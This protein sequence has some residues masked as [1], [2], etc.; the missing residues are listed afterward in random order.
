MDKDKEIGALREKI[1]KMEEADSN[2][3]ICRG[4]D[5][6]KRH[7]D[8][9]QTVKYDDFGSTE[10]NKE[11]IKAKNKDERVNVKECDVKEDKKQFLGNK[12]CRDAVADGNKNHI[13]NMDVAEKAVMK[14]ENK[15]EASINN[16]KED[17]NDVKENEDKERKL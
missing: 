2:S 17:D 4:M 6:E 11:H 14:D 16:N 10:L 8:A 9:D 15:N 5:E 13:E 12:S 3:D 1:G 7:A